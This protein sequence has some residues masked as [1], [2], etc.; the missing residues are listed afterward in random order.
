MLLR[1]VSGPVWVRV[2]RGSR[3]V[4]SQARPFPVL[5]DPLDPSCPQLEAG[6]RLAEEQLAKLEQLNKFCLGGGGEKGIAL[7]VKKNRKILPRDKLKLLLDSDSDFLELSLLA[8]LGME[9]GDVPAAGSITG[10]GRIHG[11]YCVVSC[12]D[13]TVKSGTF[14]PITVPKN[15]RAMAISGANH[16]PVVHIVDSAGG[17]L[18]KQAELFADKNHGGRAFYSEAVLSAAGVPQIAAVCGS[19]TAGGAYQPAMCEDVVIVSGLGTIF[20][21]GPPLVKAAT[22]EIITA[23]DLGGGMLH[24]KTSGVTDYLAESEHEAFEVVRDVVATLGIDP[25]PP[26]P[27]QQE[28][29]WDTALL[30]ALSGL[31]S[32]S[33]QH[34]YGIIGRIVDGARFREFKHLYGTNLIAGY[35]MIDGKCVGILGNA[36]P[37]THQDGLK[38]SH[39]LQLCQQRQLPLVFLQNS[40]PEEAHRSALLS[41]ENEEQHMHLRGR[42]A[43]VAALACVTVPKITVNVG[44][45]HG[46]DNYTMCG[47]SFS[48]NFIFSWPGTRVTHTLNPPPQPPSEATQPQEKASKKKSLSVFNFPPDSAFYHAANILN[49]GIIVPSQTRQIVSKCLRICR[50][51]EGISNSAK[52]FS[53]LRL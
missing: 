49:D 30:D 12:S 45:C 51:K 52:D 33:R 39:F 48:P 44:G 26:P 25:L 17:F 34:L 36:G 43:M 38:G 7:H 41:G 15:L 3:G 37:L 1:R 14:F 13:G 19:C 24:S 22:G 18:P 27:P 20:L 42:A 28:D 46:D 6:R 23:E 16:L 31:E 21:G 40:G 29:P 53:V 35:A 47:P 2:A 10:I 8:G 11:T 5:K 32:I 50:Q 4:A 9:Y